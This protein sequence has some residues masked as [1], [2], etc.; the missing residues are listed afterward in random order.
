MQKFLILLKDK[1][2]G[3]LTHE[4]LKQHVEHLQKLS[5]ISKLFICGPLKDNEK[6]MQ[7][8]K[9]E[10]KDEAQ[11]LVESDPFIQKGYYASY[12]VHEIIE[13]NEGNNWLF[14]DPQT[15]SNLLNQ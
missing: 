10:T 15:K 11:K 6:A 8:L 2:K 9:C 4:L 14:E 3:E 13:A 1:R 12:E 5:N 7:I